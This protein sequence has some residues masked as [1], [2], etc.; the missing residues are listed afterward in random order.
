MLALHHVE[1][2]RACAE[3]RPVRAALRVRAVACLLVG[4]AGCTEGAQL[5]LEQAAAAVQERDLAKAGNELEQAAEKTNAEVEKKIEVIADGTVE[6]AAAARAIAA[7]Q[8]AADI[9]CNGSVCTMPRAD[10][11]A[12]LG[13]PLLVAAQVSVTPESHAG[14]THWRIESVREGSTAH[15]MGLQPA[16]L[17]LRMNGKPI[18]NPPDAALLDEVRSDAHVVLELERDGKPVRRELRCPKAG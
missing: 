9:T 15:A 18:G 1:V 11:E 8:D 10:F 13:N 5:D 7:P 12:L 17:V 14:V 3:P 6:A 16:D 4:V 2:A